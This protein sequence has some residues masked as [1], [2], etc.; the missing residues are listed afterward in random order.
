MDPALWRSALLLGNYLFDG[1]SLKNLREEHAP[2]LNASPEK[3]PGLLRTE[4]YVTKKSKWAPRLVGMISSAEMAARSGFPGYQHFVQSMDLLYP[5][6]RSDKLVKPQSV[7]AEPLQKLTAKIPGGQTFNNFLTIG[8]IPILEEWLFR[9]W[10]FGAQGLPL[11]LAGV[12]PVAGVFLQWF[13]AVPFF[14]WAHRL[15]NKETGA[16]TLQRVFPAL[17]FSV[18]YILAPGAELNIVAHIFWNLWA[19]FIGGIPVM[20]MG[21]NFWFPHLD[22]MRQ[23]ANLPE[24]KSTTEWGVNLLVI[25]LHKQLARAIPRLLG[26]YREQGEDVHRL[27][28]ITANYLYNVLAPSENWG[29]VERE[30]FVLAELLFGG[31]GKLDLVVLFPELLP[32]GPEHDLLDSLGPREALSEERQVLLSRLKAIKDGENTSLKGEDGELEVLKRTFSK[33]LNIVEIKKLNI[34]FKGIDP[35]SPKKP[36]PAPKPSLPDGE[37]QTK[38]ALQEWKAFV[39]GSEADKNQ[40]YFM[41]ARYLFDILSRPGKLDGSKRDA[42]VLSELIFG[43]FRDAEIVAILPEMIPTGTSGV[44]PPLNEKETRHWNRWRRWLHRLKSIVDSENDATIDTKEFRTHFDRFMGNLPPDGRSFD[45]GIGLFLV[46][47]TPGLALG[48]FFLWAVWKAVR[49][50]WAGGFTWATR[51]EKPESLSLKDRREGGDVLSRLTP[52]PFEGIPR[53]HRLTLTDWSPQTPVVSRHDALTDAETVTLAK[54]FV[55]SMNAPMALKREGAGRIVTTSDSPEK[56]REVARVVALNDDRFLESDP[57]VDE[58][59]RGLWAETTALSE[60]VRAVSLFVAHYNAARAALVVLQW[61]QNALRSDRP[62]VVDVTPLFDDR[63][64][65]ERAPL[66]ILLTLLS[67]TPEARAAFL[68]DSGGAGPAVGATARAALGA[69]FPG[70]FQSERPLWGRGEDGTEDIFQAEGLSLRAVLRRLGAEGVALHGLSPDRLIP[71]EQ[72]GW[73]EGA[74]L[75]FP[76]GGFLSPALEEALRRHAFLQIQ[77]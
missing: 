3:L 43:G 74:V 73:A 45:L 4:R 63:R 17:L 70:L 49:F 65:A 32:E 11:W 61:Q 62:Q 20:S 16:E 71:A 27:V 77:A 55:A 72:D 68:L 18:L 33:L 51:S 25:D 69:R 56:L 48:G 36:V 52:Q 35:Y 39:H 1:K 41:T 67:H 13:L 7:L 47:L 12:D 46:F 59:I 34:K 57:T 30:A 29:E 15:G 64:A 21:K 14:V 6:F 50:G 66:E 24:K 58:A 23:G 54:Q 8:L 44:Y 53:L 76:L 19:V 37:R 28:P 75:W 9:H 22:S 60:R 40:V 26:A 2:L 10:V 42:L 31:L 38:R 5:P